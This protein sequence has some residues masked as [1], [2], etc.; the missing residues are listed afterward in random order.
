MEYLVRSVWDV[1]NSTKPPCTEKSGYVH[2]EFELSCPVIDLKE[3]VEGRGGAFC[4][5]VQRCGGELRGVMVEGKAV[6]Q[7]DVRAVQ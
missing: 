1:I 5:S 3:A 2:F 7:S 6:E 4:R